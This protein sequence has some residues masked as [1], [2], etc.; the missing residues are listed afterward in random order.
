MISFYNAQITNSLKTYHGRKQHYLCRKFLCFVMFRWDQYFNLKH[1]VCKCI[2]AFKMVSQLIILTW[3]YIYTMWVNCL[4]YLYFI[5]SLHAIICYFLSN[6]SASD[7]LDDQMQRLLLN[8]SLKI[9]TSPSHK[10]RTYYDKTAKESSQEQMPN[11]H[12]SSQFNGTWMFR[13][14][15]AHLQSLGFDR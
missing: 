1:C 3:N 12:F 13:M 11:K 2:I 8:L 9:G 6:I 15:P 10:F 7:T 4:C 14:I 5:I